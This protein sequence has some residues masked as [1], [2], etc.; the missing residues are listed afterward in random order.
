M[1]TFLSTGD[2]LAARVI[3]TARRSTGHLGQ[4]AKMTSV[5]VKS[6]VSDGN[7]GDWKF[8][9]G[10][11]TV[12]LGNRFHTNITRAPYVRRGSF[13][14]ANDKHAA[15]FGAQILRHEKWH[16]LA[17][18]RD[19]PA[20][21]AACRR[22]GV[23]FVVLNVLE[24]IRIEYKAAKIEGKW[25][26]WTQ[27]LETRETTDATHAILNL[28]MAET[29]GGWAARWTTASS[30]DLD[31]LV[32]F[33]EKARTAVDSW[34]IVK[35]AKEFV[36]RFGA[37]NPPTEITEGGHLHDDIGDDNDGSAGGKAT[38]G[39]P[40]PDAPSAEADGNVEVDDNG[41]VVIPKGT[42]KTNAAQVHWTEFTGG[43]YNV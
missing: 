15:Q 32:V 11:H 12:R 36:D 39:T 17:T 31:D 35:L 8:D 29:A 1:L 6:E 7:T 37:P 24:D 5:A 16:G 10:I 26:E 18:V 27:W 21:A 9:G 34:A 25:F 28:K 42:P 2:K 22:D 38:R 40:V 3:R 33:F 13:L 30:A 19:V 43:F 4:L 23:P 14:H 41:E 20:L